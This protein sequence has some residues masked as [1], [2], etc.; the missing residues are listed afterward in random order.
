VS[1]DSENSLSEPFASLPGLDIQIGAFCN[2]NGAGEATFE[3]FST[4]LFSVS[5]LYYASG[6]AFVTPVSGD[7]QPIN[8]LAQ[9]DDNGQSGIFEINAS[10]T[11]QVNANLVVTSDGLTASVDVFMA[12]STTTQ[13]EV[14]GIG[15]PGT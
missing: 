12:G 6:V 8:D 9:R 13:C 10:T 11:A 3:I 1:V 5:G 2:I 7:P 4:G 15:V 14:R